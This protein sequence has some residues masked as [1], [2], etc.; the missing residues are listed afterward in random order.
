MF[1]NFYENQI[2]E[3]LW[4][5]DF[6]SWFTKEFPKIKKKNVHQN[7]IFIPFFYFE[8]Y[9]FMVYQFL[10]FCKCPTETFHNLVVL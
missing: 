8:K 10:A 5:A 3:S 9:S 2:C 1:C 7:K 4:L 6:E